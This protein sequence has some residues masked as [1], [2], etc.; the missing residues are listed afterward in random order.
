MTKGE[1]G[2]EGIEHRYPGNVQAD[3][4]VREDLGASTC[5]FPRDLEYVDQSRGGPSSPKPE[6]CLSSRGII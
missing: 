3:L 6:N 1:V 5:G 2:K 4:V